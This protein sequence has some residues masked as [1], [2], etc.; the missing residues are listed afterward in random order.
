MDDL[1]LAYR[2]CAVVLLLLAGID[3]DVDDGHHK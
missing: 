1:I 2:Q 3:I